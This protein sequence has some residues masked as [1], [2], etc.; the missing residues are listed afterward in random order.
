MSHVPRLAIHNI[1]KL[2]NLATW[3]I[4]NYAVELV[5]RGH[6]QY[7]YFD[8]QE[9]FSNIRT[10]L[11]ALNQVRKQYGWRDLG[12][13]KARIIFTRKALDENVDVLLNFNS[14]QISEFT[15]AIKAFKGIK[16]FHLMDYFWAEPGSQKNSRLVEHGVD[17]VMSYGRS[18]RHCAYFKRFF[19][20]YIAH[21]I[22]VPFGFD[23][24]FKKTTPFAKRK[25]K[26]VAL[27][28]VN[29]LRPAD[30]DPINYKESA[31]FFA[32]ENWFHKF[33]RMI[34]ED[35]SELENQVD[36]MLPVFPKYK[37][38]NYDIVSKFNT[39]KMFTSCESIFYFPAAKTF[40]GPACNT[41]MVCSD[42]PC[43]QDYGFVDGV[44]CITHQSYDVQ[45]MKNKI[46]YYIRHE[47]ELEKVAERGHAF[48]HQHY[49][50]EAIANNLAHIFNEIYF[51][52]ATSNERVPLNNIRFWP[53]TSLKV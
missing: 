9:P 16:I 50:H 2:P 44:N 42:H 13:D 29:P 43:F 41:A 32:A 5:R 27:G 19:P 8:E 52:N 14:A 36:S 6:V 23:Q 39:Y 49:S 18:D 46:A 20:S 33:R 10:K 45:D 47:D 26:C 15:P 30:T 37:D 25:S 51:A 38:P 24:R 7:L 1:H 4:H 35:L 21:V 34:V 31:E 17:Y 11:S 3:K 53:Y 12:F 40:E 22:P 48:V 28:S